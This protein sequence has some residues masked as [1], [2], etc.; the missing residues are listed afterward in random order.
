[1]MLTLKQLLGARRWSLIPVPSLRQLDQA[2]GDT[3]PFLGT[4]CCKAGTSS[5]LQ[6]S[7]LLDLTDLTLPHK[8]YPS[9]R[10]KKRLIVLHVGPTNSG[11]TFK[12]LQRLQLCSSGVYCGPLRLLA[13]EVAERLNK[14]NTACS[15]ITG[16]ERREV[17]GARHK[18]MTVEMADISR[19]YECGVI[20]EIQ[21]IGCQERGFSFTRA[22]LGL[23]VNELHLCGDPA[24]VPLIQDIIATTGDSL[25]VQH[26][27]RLSPLVPLSRPLKAYSNVKRGDCII[28]FS[29]R[30]IFSIKKKI[31]AEGK[32]KCA[33][34]Y[35]SLPPEART[36]QAE[37]FNDSSSGYDILVASDAIGMGLNL[38]I[39]RIVFSTLEKFD[40]TRF[41][42]LDVMQ[43]K[44][45][46]GRAGRYGSSFQK[47][48]VTCLDLYDLPR[49]HNSI[50]APSVPI[51]AAGLFPSLDQLA[52]Y[53]SV[54]SSRTFAT[55][56]EVAR[57]LDE[58]P[59]SIKDRFLFCICPIDLDN[60]VVTGALL[61]FATEYC[62]Y[63]GVS[64]GTSLSSSST[65]IPRT[66]GALVELE[67][68]NKVFDLYIWLS[69]RLEDAFVDRDSA[70][71]QKELCGILIEAGLK[72][73]GSKKTKNVQIKRQ[74]SGFNTREKSQANLGGFSVDKDIG[75]LL[76]SK[77]NKNETWKESCIFEDDVESSRLNLSIQE[78]DYYERK[79]CK[80]AQGPSQLWTPKWV[81]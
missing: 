9:A 19:E 42:P 68:L 1:M 63:G 78:L 66:Q 29:R 74:A 4:F 34:V 26:Y 55:I 22:L 59:M 69:F 39:R 20:D 77:K 46:A 67:S 79:D 6:P 54:H 14:S 48:E 33:V 57:L 58:F 25:Q 17:D 76:E 40:G 62:K 70:I 3:S 53:S 18:A 13:W 47:G 27:S 36:R 24:V 73:V 45:I 2:E 50:A 61:K 21:M 35:G 80:K 16:Q 32:F 30:E 64:L 41:R 38:N 81:S 51:K 56:L 37:Q 49:L 75:D 11:K 28:A 43:I 7:T 44:Q 12:A 72:M 15:L 31:E 10:S 8:W 52:L 60:Q 65:Q 5:K 71:T 23:A